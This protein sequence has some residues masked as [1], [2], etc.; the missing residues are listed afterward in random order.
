MKTKGDNL[1]FWMMSFFSREDLNFASGRQ[2]GER[3]II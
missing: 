3:Q 2:L 1:S